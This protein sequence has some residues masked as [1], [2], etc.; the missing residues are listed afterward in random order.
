MV[1]KG[2]MF[3]SLGTIKGVGMGRL[4]FHSQSWQT[5]N[6]N[7]NV[8]KK[9][10]KKAERRLNPWDLLLRKNGDCETSGWT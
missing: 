2:F 3:L 5:L 1:I 8:N 10:R 4:P 9:K 7:A 6:Q